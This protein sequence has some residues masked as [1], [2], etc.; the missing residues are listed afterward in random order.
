[1]AR[2]YATFDNSTI[3]S[4][5][6]ETSGNRFERRNMTGGAS[7]KTALLAARQA[8]S[9]AFYGVVDAANE[10]GASGIVVPNDGYTRSGGNF[11][12]S[13]L[14][15]NAG[16]NWQS[17]P[18]TRPTALITAA[19][20][21]AVSP[22]D[23]GSISETLYT[24]ANTALQNVLNAIT[25][26]PYTRL[27]QNPYRTLA[28]LWHDHDM[29]YFAWDDFTPGQPATLSPSG[30]SSQSAASDLVITI[31][32]SRQYKA[33]IEGQIGLYATL[34]KLGGSDTATLDVNVAASGLSYVWTVPGGTLPAG[35]YRLD[36]SGTFRDVTITTNEGTPQ[37][38]TSGPSTAFVTLT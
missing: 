36:I 1:M 7:L 3:S 34:T 6:A 23:A 25:N 37:T 33:D 14:Y 21:T 27:G 13:N 29:T 16:A 19:G 35:G 2:W 28:S 12:F 31:N 10:N 20:S 4:L 5:E 30:P 11:S 18:R 22:T 32:W 24:D 8:L 15:T 9:D 26:G 17:N 38:Y